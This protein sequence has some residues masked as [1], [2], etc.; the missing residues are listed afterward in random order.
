MSSRQYD[1]VVIGAGIGGLGAAALLA[2]DFSKKVLVAERA[3][4]IGGRAVSFTE[5]SLR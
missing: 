1:V 5:T 4:F 3:P 2:K